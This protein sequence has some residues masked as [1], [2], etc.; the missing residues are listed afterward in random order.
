[1]NRLSLASVTGL[2]DLLGLAFQVR[3]RSTA[4]TVWLAWTVLL[5]RSWLEF[6]QMERRTAAT[7]GHSNR[8]AGCKRMEDLWWF[9]GVSKKR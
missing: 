4:M 8:A 7:A 3:D 1:M 5:G 6:E 2:F 9:L